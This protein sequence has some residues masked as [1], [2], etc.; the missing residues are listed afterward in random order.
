MDRNVINQTKDESE[1][2]SGERR[3]S[4]I[5]LRCRFRRGHSLKSPVI[6]QL[7]RVEDEENSVH[8]AETL[9]VF[10]NKFTL[11]APFHASLL[12]WACNDGAC[13]RWKLE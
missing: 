1:Y 7:P 3:N 8:V 4:A 5:S 11:R 13:G 10:V 12:E 9:V 6:R 2:Y